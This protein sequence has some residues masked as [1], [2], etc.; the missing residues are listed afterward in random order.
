MLG[1][2]F[3]SP[4]MLAVAIIIPLDSSG[5]ILFRQQRIGRGFKPFTLLKF[6]TMVCH[7]DRLGPSITKRND[8]RITRVGR[9][10]R[11]TKIDEFPQ[12]LN[13]IKGDMSLVG[14]RPEVPMY[15]EMFREDYKEILGVRPGITDRASI[16][17]RN[18]ADILAAAEDSEALY[19]MHILPEKLALAKEYV[20]H[21]SIPLDIVLLATT[22]FLL[23]GVSRDTTTKPGGPAL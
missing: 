1:L 5:G 13:V 23:L 16:R 11:K 17:Y 14:P 8:A 18:E 15:V 21:N 12:L 6:R 9:F 19:H 4:L 22:L 10:L 7:A 2:V 3:V 20:R